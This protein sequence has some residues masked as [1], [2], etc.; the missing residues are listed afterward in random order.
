MAR[1]SK[2]TSTSVT[3][4]FTGVTSNTLL[5][6]GDY[7]LKVLEVKNESNSDEGSLKW[8]WEVVKA[9]DKKLIGKTFSDFTNL[10]PQSLWNLKQRLEALNVDVPDSELEIDLEELV[11]L[12]LEASLTHREWEDRKYNQLGSYVSVDGEDEEEEDEKPAKKRKKVEDEEDED[13]RPSRVKKKSKKAKEE[14]PCPT[15]V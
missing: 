7:R 3:L 12:E 2:K 8:L 11:D 4:D 13:E 14:K 6:E 15:S 5:P 10:A 9:E 1:K